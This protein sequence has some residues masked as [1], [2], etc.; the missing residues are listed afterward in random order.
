MS[1]RPVWAVA[2]ALF[3]AAGI[4]LGVVA[5]ASAHARL[6]ESSPATGEVVGASPAQVSI[7]YTQEIQKITGTYSIIV[8]DEGG[9]DVTAAPAVVNE[10]DRANVTV[11][12][13]P[14]LPSG[15][16][17]VHYTNVSDADADP[18]EGAFAFYVG[19]EPTA[20]ELAEDAAL[21]GNEEETPAATA[22]VAA[23][24]SPAATR[25]VAPAS[26]R[27]AAP[28]G[29]TDGDDGGGVAVGVIVAAA[30]AVVVA[31]GGAYYMLRRGR[32]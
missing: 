17:V 21:P 3:A 10:A 28:P 23:T 22:S 7:T 13:R 8:R 12:L 6:K 15:R 32:S 26:S 29:G 18:F 9:A 4:A 31:G 14:S 1:E 5:V 27:T 25:T 24:A 16:Y 20:E 11:A 2:V 30:V 19:R